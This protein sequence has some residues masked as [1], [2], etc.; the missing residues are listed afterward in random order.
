MNVFSLDVYMQI[1]T[2]ITNTLRKMDQNNPWTSSKFLI[3]QSLR[4]LDLASCCK[5]PPPVSSKDMPVTL[6]KFFL[7]K[8]SLSVSPNCPITAGLSK[9]SLSQRKTYS[10]ALQPP[11]DSRRHGTHS[12]NLV[13]SCP[14]PRCCLRQSC[15]SSLSTAYL[16]VSKVN[17]IIACEFCTIQPD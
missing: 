14:Q 4:N 7:G 13:H 12:K 16:T 15:R 5:A 9:A 17:S 6:H 10:C 8:S 11:A 3:E 2:H 1:Y